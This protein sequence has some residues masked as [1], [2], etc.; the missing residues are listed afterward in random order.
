VVVVQ[1]LALDPENAR[2][3]S[4]RRRILCERDVFFSEGGASGEFELP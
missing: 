2:M 1:R 3:A 4:E